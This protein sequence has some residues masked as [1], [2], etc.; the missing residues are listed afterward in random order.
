MEYSRLF[1]AYQYMALEDS[2]QFLNFMQPQDWVAAIYYDMNQ[3]ILTDF[4][5][6]QTQLRSD[7]QNLSMRIP[8]FSENNLYDSLAFTLDRMKGVEGRKSILLISTGCDSFSKLNY[9]Q[10]L[11]IVKSSNTVIYPVST[12]EFFTVRYGDNFPC[13]PGMPGYGSSLNALQARNALQ[14]I[15]K[16]SGGQAYFPRFEQD[17]PDIYQQIAGQLRTQYGLGFIPTDPAKDGRFHKLKVDV[18]GAE[19]QPLKIIDQKGK[20]VKY[21]I[22]ARDG[23]YA[24]KS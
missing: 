13:T 17:I 6:D 10:I 16:Y 14:T 7:L 20:K 8:D 4:T 22:V 3:H 9:D 18:V 21:R 1:W 19:G 15:A 11:K 23:Y 12:L 2:I 24:P 5:H